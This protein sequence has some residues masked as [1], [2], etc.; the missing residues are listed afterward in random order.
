MTD[1]ALR[2]ASPV[3][4]R[5]VT[6]HM[7]GLSFHKVAGGGHADLQVT[8]NLARAQF[9]DLGPDC[10]AY[11]YDRAG[12]TIWEGFINNPGSSY[13]DAGESFDLAALGIKTLASD[14]AQPVLYRETSYDG[15]IPA[16]GN[17]ASATAEVGTF[18]DTAG[19]LSGTPAVLCQINPGQPVG[20][21]AG[22][23]MMYLPTLTGRD[24]WI[25]GVRLDRDA[26]RTDANWRTE[27][28]AYPAGAALYSTTMDG[29]A[30]R[31]DMLAGVGFPVGQDHLSFWIQHTGA[32]T[33]VAL[34]DYWVGLGGLPGIYAITGSLRNAAGEQPPPR[35][36]YLLASEVVTD[37]AF[38][39][40]GAQLDPNRTSVAATSYQ[41]DQ[42]AY[43]TPTRMQAILDDL[44]VWEPDMTWEILPSIGDTYG[45]NYR[46]WGT[47]P[48]YEISTRDGFTQPGSD[49]DLCNRVAIDWTDAT[50]KPQ[51]TVVTS[52][53][54]ALGARVRDADP[55]TLPAGRGSAANATRLGQSILAA[56]S[57][58]PT[59]ATATV[60]RRI[61]DMQTGRMVAPWEIE[62]G[63]VAHVRET[64]QDLRLTEMTYTHDDRSAA[65]TLGDPVYDTDQVVAA[66]VNGRQLIPLNSGGVYTP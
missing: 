43:A 30:S 54:P 1:L 35:T 10:K 49:A 31:V 42:L 14:S 60:T 53:V 48:R 16:G 44:A 57:T 13:A 12:R 27:L 34:N 18:P 8:L 3:S 32:A 66:L 22:R 61:R 20:A 4:D 38:R 6:R 55:V 24:Q 19:I 45:L 46:P 47:D 15:W 23:A 58:A 2:I 41:I 39:F 63:Y 28:K 9:P 29:T 62:P 52:T 50:G 59:A 17:L 25:G 7:S 11:V 37:A 33:N 26:G 65:L 40:L 36:A 5:H 56:A 51:T 21:A 64:G